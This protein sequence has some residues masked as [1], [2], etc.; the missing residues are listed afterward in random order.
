MKN[1]LKFGLLFLAVVALVLVPMASAYPTYVPSKAPSCGVCHVNPGGGGKLTPAGAIF[2]STGK[3]PV[4]TPTPTPTPAP[5]PKPSPAPTP[6]P[7]PAP[8]PDYTPVLKKITISPSAANLALNGTKIFKVAPRDQKGNLISVK[9]TWKSSN[10]TVGTIDSTG[11][12]TALKAGK[13]TITASKGKINGSATI[14][15]TTKKANNKNKEN[16]KHKEH[17]KHHRNKKHDEIEEHKEKD[18]H[19][20][21]DHDEKDEDEHDED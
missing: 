11:K 9:I 21:K 5:T 4:I 3:L 10:K 14:T 16:K 8:S 12:F 2:K 13:T 7:T 6:A 18:E 17:K 20:D 15:V 19:H 1:K